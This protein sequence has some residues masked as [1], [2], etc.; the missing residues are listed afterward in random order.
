[1]SIIHVNQ[2]KS[3][4]TRLFEG[5][6]D[7]SDLSQ[8]KSSLDNFFLSRSLAAYAIHFLSNCEL[9]QAAQSVTDGGNDNGIDGI[10]FDEKDKRLFIVQSKW[11]HTGKGEPDNGDVKKFISG[12]VDL[13]NVKF[14]NFNDKVRAKKDIVLKALDDPY[15]RSSLVI[16]YTGINSLAQHSA[17]DLETLKNDLND[18]SDMIDI[19]VLNQQ[20]LHSTLTVGLLGDPIFLDISIK[21]WGKISSPYLGYYGQVC[22]SQISNWWQQYHFRLFSKNLRNILGD[23]EVNSEIRNTLK[24]F[25]ENFWYFNN[26]ITIVAKKVIKTMAHGSDTEYGTF[27]CEDVSI[28]NGAQTVGTIGR[29]SENML[30]DFSEVHVPVRIISLENAPLNFGEQVTRTNNRQNKI[31]NRDFVS[32]DQEQ[33]R[34]KQE[35]AIDG[36]TYNIARSEF[37]TLNDKSFDLVESTTALACASGKPYLTVLVKKEMGKLWENI[38]TTPY[39]EI[40]NKSVSGMYMWR[41]VKVQRMIDQRLHFIQKKGTLTDVDEG[42]I[43]HGN[44]I[45]STLTFFKIGQSNLNNCNFDFDDSINIE[46]VKEI[47]E[48]SLD[49]IRCF[50]ENRYKLPVLTNVF[51]NVAKCKEILEAC[52]S[53]S[54]QEAL[55]GQIPFEF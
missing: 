39:K 32:L 37:C 55:I 31:E 44:R 21:C 36:I 5:K 10:F 9:D 20:K 51:K 12:V 19:V 35:L 45:V 54:P 49:N 3:R 1:M 38:D 24:N 28:V 8:H 26:G 46:Y 2:I 22:A 6:I 23:T 29:F 15:C 41:C 47:V 17:R 42:I 34:I 52:K 48:S 18:T 30:S 13:F 25:P 53:E 7:L 14:D 4:I 50:I 43:F 16:A 40:F 11:I 27:H 33:N